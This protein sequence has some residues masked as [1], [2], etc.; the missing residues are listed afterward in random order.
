MIDEESEKGKG[1]DQRIIDR[2]KDFLQRSMDAET[3]N[4]QEGLQALKFSKLG[5]QWLTNDVQS[6]QAEARPC[7]TINKTEAFCKQVTNQQRQQRP[8]IKVHAVSGGADVKIANIIAGI[9]RHIEVNSNADT[10]YDTAFDSAVHIGW[11]YFRLRHDFINDT[12]FDQDIFIDS[13][14]NPFSVYF[15]PNSSLPDGSDQV[16]CLITDNIA[17]KQFKLQYPDASDGSNFIDGGSGDDM[18]DWLSEND[19]R[20]AEYYYIETVKDTLCLL[21]DKSVAWKDELPKQMPEGLLLVAE[22]PSYR[23]KVK[24]C[25]L[26]AMDVLEKRDVPGRYIPVIPVY[27]ECV[28]IEGKRRR[29]GLVK[30]AMDPQRMFNFWRTATTESVALAPKA[31]WLMADGQDEGFETEWANAN[32]ATYPVLHH[33]QVDTDGRAAERPERLQPEPPPAGMIE[34]ANLMGE[35]LSTVLGIVDPAQRITGN[36]S[37]KALNSEKQQSDNSTF[38]YYDNLTRSICHA[39]KIILEWTPKIYDT[40]R[41]LRIIGEDGRP[42][43]VTVNEQTA[44]G[45]VMNDITVGVYDVVMDTGPG[46]NSK[47]IEAV[48]TFMQ[49]LATPLGEEVAK[50]GADLA[51]RAMDFPGSDDLADRLAAA[52]P[53]AQ[54]DEKSDIPPQAQMMIKG[55]Q[56]QIQQAGEHIQG[57][58]M[59]LKYRGDVVDKQEAAETNREHMRLVSKA[60]DVETQANSK[61][62]A[63]QEDNSAWM[64]QVAVDA[65]TRLSVA[66]ISAMSKLLDS[67]V[68]GAQAKEIQEPINESQEE[69][70]EA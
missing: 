17:K 52:N 33:K 18:T 30:H 41:V 2:A 70:I 44:L 54:I 67:H 21:S 45:E 27:G 49:L 5:E 36:V 48:D 64:H 42:D 58:E 23:R 50:V 37:G 1:E 59:Q 4:R 8:R 31:K 15:D 6:R 65:H 56:Q 29:F 9:C 34:N 20:I 26:T 32:V 60:H 13:V 19:I 11:G 61:F 68:K 63:N 66:E 57:L 53:L 69:A 25:K 40:E 46:Y 62:M 38:H 55:L 47:R 22:R 51:V 39:G 16:E 14:D 3:Q 7:L 24:W 35:D 12:S 43:Q 28:V 10:A